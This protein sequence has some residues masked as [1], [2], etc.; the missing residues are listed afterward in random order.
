MPRSRIFTVERQDDT[1]ILV[2][3]GTDITFADEEVLTE[4]DDVLYRLRES[5]ARNLLIDF[6]QTAYFGSILLGSVL[7]FGT[8]LRDSGGRFALCNMSAS[9][10]EMLRIAR[11]DTLWPIYDTREAA[12]AAMQQPDG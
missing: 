3:P 8:R 2:L 9:G 5:G 6:G 7:K 12:L 11:F 1:L 4:V 10:R